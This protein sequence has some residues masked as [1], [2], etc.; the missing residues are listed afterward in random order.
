MTSEQSRCSGDE[1]NCAKALEDL[2][3]YLDGELP[4][5]HL[6]G[7]RQH[8]AHCYPCAD[9]I[10]FE[11]QLRAIVRERCAAHAPDSLVSR[12]RMRLDELAETGTA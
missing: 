12:I 8:L 3:L 1:P 5:G 11:E 10:S 2:Q 4:E 7:I 6:H 9:R